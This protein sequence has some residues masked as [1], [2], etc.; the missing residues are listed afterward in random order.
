MEKEVVFV[1][2]CIVSFASSVVR[3]VLSCVGFGG[4]QSKASCLMTQ[5]MMKI[6]IKVRTLQICGCILTCWQG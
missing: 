3:V 4:H 1:M 6:W 5:W 2:A